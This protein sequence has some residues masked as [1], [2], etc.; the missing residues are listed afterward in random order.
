MEPNTEDPQNNESQENSIPLPL[1][2][3]Y[4]DYIRQFKQGTGRSNL[5]QDGDRTL[6]LKDIPAVMALLNEP[7]VPKEKLDAIIE[8]L[9]LPD[10]QDHTTIENFME[11][12]V[13]YLENYGSKDEFIQAFQVLDEEGKGEIP[14]NKLRYFMLEYGEVEPTQLD[15]MIMDIFGMKKNAPID[16]LKPVDYMAFAAKI[17]D[18][19]E[20][21]PKGK[22][23][24]GRGK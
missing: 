7:K 13:P 14:V 20:K 18:K 12:V 21:K 9:N 4:I 17:F 23:K 6:F 3:E 11:V 10:D 5:D 19:P 1:R 2:N 16:P 24:N 15:S 22:P 8:E